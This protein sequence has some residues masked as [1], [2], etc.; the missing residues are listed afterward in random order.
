MQSYC[1]VS[2]DARGYVIEVYSNE[3]HSFCLRIDYIC[4]NWRSPGSYPPHHACVCFVLSRATDDSAKPPFSNQ[5]VCNQSSLQ[6][7]QCHQNRKR[8]SNECFVD[9][10]KL[11]LLSSLNKRSVSLFFVQQF[12]Q[13]I[14]SANHFNLPN[15]SRALVGFSSPLYSTAFQVKP[16]EEL[17]PIIRLPRQVG[18]LDLT[19]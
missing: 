5:P 14:R 17:L 12:G 19:A 15:S 3:R 4:R 8:N 2:P 6:P 13:F 18:L 16:V 9:T 7:I 1:G 10:K 11:L